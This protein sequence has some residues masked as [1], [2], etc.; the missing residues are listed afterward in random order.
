[1]VTI[2]QA[3]FKF[4]TVVLFSLLFKGA[5]GISVFSCLLIACCYA[6]RFEISITIYQI[7]TLFSIENFSVLV[8]MFLLLRT[9]HLE[10][11]ARSA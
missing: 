11:W 10:N 8:K 3:I 1:M 6:V 2:V 9:G 5:V 7:N 4:C